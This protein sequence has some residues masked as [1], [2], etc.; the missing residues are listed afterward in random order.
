MILNLEPKER[1]MAPTTASF[2]LPLVISSKSDFAR[3]L[4]ELHAIDEFLNQAAIR[5]PGS[6]LAMPKISK[7]MQEVALV[8]KTNLLETSS[9]RGLLQAFMAY[10]ASPKIVHI[11]FA[12]EPSL[13]FLQKVTSWMRENIDSLVLLQIGLQPD[14]AAGCTVRTTNKYFDLSLRKEMTKHRKELIDLISGKV[15]AAETAQIQAE[16]QQAAAQTKDVTAEPA[17][18]EI[19][20]AEAQVPVTPTAPADYSVPREAPVEMLA[21]KKVD[22]VQQA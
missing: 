11:S 17:T 13:V 3:L 4:R 9:R 18:T 2:Q 8:N 10:H 16:A 19:T 1:P 5:Q 22:E 6:S 20:M 15:T 14:I 7:A 12:A 21:D